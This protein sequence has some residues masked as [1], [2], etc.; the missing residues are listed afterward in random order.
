MSVSFES[1]S[2]SKLVEL[3]AANWDPWRDFHFW[4]G[5]CCRENLA[6]KS[7]SRRGTCSR[8]CSGPPCLTGP[9]PD[10]M[11]SNANKRTHSKARAHTHTRAPPACPSVCCTAGNGQTW[12]FNG[13]LEPP[14]TLEVLWAPSWV[15]HISGLHPVTVLQSHH[16]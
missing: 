3:T 16:L 9:E 8:H 5:L 13:D 15:L 1:V 12:T 2:G 7:D 11:G 6:W 10:P 4:G 14:N